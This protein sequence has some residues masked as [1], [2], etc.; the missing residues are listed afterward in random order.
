MSVISAAGSSYSK[1]APGPTPAAPPA[2][3]GVSSLDQSISSPLST[4]PRIL[5]SAIVTITTGNIYGALAFE[6]SPA[7]M[8]YTKIRCT[9]GSTITAVTALVL[10]LADQ[11][12]IIIAQTADLTGTINTINTFY[13][14]IPLLAPVTT[15]P[16]LPYY[17][18]IGFVGTT[19]NMAGQAPRTSAMTG[20]LGDS[21]Q[22]SKGTSGYAGGALLNLSPATTGFSASL[23]WIE[24]IP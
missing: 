4:M 10:G 6:R 5:A 22:L 17:P 13:D 21:P 15:Q 24:L 3:R 14:N 16:G 9:S 23:P 19:L 20:A 18:C 12:G 2:Q 7:G 1:A 11:N 8:T